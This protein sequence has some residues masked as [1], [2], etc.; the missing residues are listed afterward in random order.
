MTNLPGG[1]TW[2]PMQ[3]PFEVAAIVAFW[4]IGAVGLGGYGAAA[5][6][7]VLPTAALVMWQAS[8]V[9]ASSLGAAAAVLARRQP[10]MALLCER[11]FLL[12]VGPLAAVYAA[13]VL[14]RSGTGGIVPVVYFGVYAVAAMVRLRQA[15]TYLRWRSQMIAEL[16]GHDERTAG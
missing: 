16:R 12:G 15:N 10:L 7:Q 5:L 14:V 13:A 8:L 11:I 1:P 4:V 3:H 9:V 6:V 2:P